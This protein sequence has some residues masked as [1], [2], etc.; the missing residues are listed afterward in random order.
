MPVLIRPRW[1]SHTELFSISQGKCCCVIEIL[2]FFILQCI[3]MDWRGGSFNKSF[4]R[5]FAAKESQKG[6]GYALKIISGEVSNVWKSVKQITA[7]LWKSMLKNP[8]SFGKCMGIQHSVLLLGRHKGSFMK[9]LWSAAWLGRAWRGNIDWLWAQ[10]KGG[11]HPMGFWSEKPRLPWWCQS[12]LFSLS[13]QQSSPTRHHSHDQRPS[14]LVKKKKLNHNSK[15][16][17]VQFLNFS[18][19][20]GRA[21]INERY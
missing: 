16:H 7:A 19:L 1:W 4:G 15:V 10:Y 21:L 6:Q 13:V 12:F 3:Q 11:E 2:P 18:L 8:W 17:F 9:K 20:V 5:S 14:F